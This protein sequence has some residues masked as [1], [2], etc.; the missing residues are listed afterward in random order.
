M[1]FSVRICFENLDYVLCSLA[2]NV[3]RAPY[4]TL[5]ANANFAGQFNAHLS[6][7]SG[8]RWYPSTDALHFMRAFPVPLLAQTV[9]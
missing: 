1:P 5:S 7:F 4:L 2:A 9:V 6:Q 3:T 8:N